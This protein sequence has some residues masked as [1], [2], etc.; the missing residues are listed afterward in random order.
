MAG[1]LSFFSDTANEW[2]VD[3]FCQMWM[4]KV[5]A[6][7]MNKPLPKQGFFLKAGEAIRTPDIHVGN[8][9]ACSWNWY[10]GLFCR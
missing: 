7:P 4:V 8:V 9:M 3:G 5:S 10:K 2:M 1:G 6:T